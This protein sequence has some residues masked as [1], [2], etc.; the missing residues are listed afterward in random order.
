MTQ[1]VIFLLL[2]SLLVLVSEKTIVCFTRLAECLYNDE[3]KIHSLTTHGLVHNLMNL[4]SSSNPSSMN[5][6]LYTQV[7][8]LLAL[9][10]SGDPS[11][12]LDIL[13]EGIAST[14]NDALTGS[15]KSESNPIFFCVL[16]K[17]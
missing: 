10:C 17:S 9:L 14:L 2:T 16:I 15:G 7:V 6:S 11:L 8:R 4:I 12:A 13:K 3:K 1:K 5:S